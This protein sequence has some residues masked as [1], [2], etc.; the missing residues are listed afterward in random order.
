MSA[1]F[2]IRKLGAQGDGIAETETGDLFIPFTLPGETVTASR[3]R[4]RA[5]LMAV[6]EASPLR[7]DPACRHFTECGGCA[8]QHFEAE[9]YRQWKREKVVHALK[10]KAIDC[11]IGEL[12]ACGGLAQKSPLVMQVF[13]DVTNRSIRLPRSVHAAL[14]AEAKAEGVSL[15]QLC[16]SKLVAQLRA[17]I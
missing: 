17:V 3:E 8:L 6:L 13:S 9:A 16:L 4:D 7:I 14:L 11:E 12:V 2:S 1:R 15:N 10:G 5:M